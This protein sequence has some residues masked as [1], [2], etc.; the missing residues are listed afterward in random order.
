MPTLPAVPVLSCA[1][2]H[3]V[4]LTAVDVPGI[5]AVATTSA[6]AV[7][8]TVV[9]TSST[10]VSTSSGVLI[11]PAFP[12]VPVLSCAGVDPVA[13]TAVDV[14]GILAVA[15]QPLLLLPSLYCWRP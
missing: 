12:D 7:V 11:L 5:L 10:G 2:V 6:I 3:P 9:Y 8:P 14:L 1:G 4:A 15:L 13:L